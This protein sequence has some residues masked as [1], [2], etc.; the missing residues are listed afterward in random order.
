MKK[1]LKSEICE[2][3]VLFTGLT[4]V[5]NMVERSNS[6]A[7]IHEQCMNSSHT[8]SLNACQKKIKKRKMQH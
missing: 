6:A 5:L 4:G 7:T 8:I 1:L 3:R 2:S